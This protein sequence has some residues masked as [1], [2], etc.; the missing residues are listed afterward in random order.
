MHRYT[1]LALAGLVLGC[2]SADLPV[3]AGAPDLSAT[4]T[5]SVQ[6]LDVSV[7]IADACTG[8]TVTLAGRILVVTGE[9]FDAGGGYHLRIRESFHMT[10]AGLTSG[11]PYVATHHQTLHT[12][13][14]AGSTFRQ[15]ERLRLI[16]MGAGPNAVAVF[17]LRFTVNANG[18]VTASVSDIS[19]EC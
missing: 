6:Q 5:H 10:G 13:L 12:R 19:L 2:G 1:V 3:A 17:V 15:E 11:T 18:D 14:A 4:R 7:A 9:I 8:E 16:T